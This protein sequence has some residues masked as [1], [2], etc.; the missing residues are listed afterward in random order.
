MVRWKLN[1]KILPSVL[2]PLTFICNLGIDVFISSL[3]AG[4]FILPLADVDVGPFFDI[5]RIFVVECP[6]ALDDIFLELAVVNVS[7]GEELDPHAVLL[8]VSDVAEVEPAVHHVFPR[9]CL[10][11]VP[12]LVEFFGFEEGVY[13]LH[14]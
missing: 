11:C 5:L 6:A 10:L 4:G 7:I 14:G 9:P 1:Q 3:A 13:F 8:T 2:I 12:G